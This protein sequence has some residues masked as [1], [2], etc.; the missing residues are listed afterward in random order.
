MKLKDIP[1]FVKFI[2]SCDNCEDCFSTTDSEMLKFVV[3]ESSGE[4]ISGLKI[5]Q[6]LQ[7]EPIDEN[8]NK[9]KVI[10]II[11]R[12]LFNDTDSHKY[13]F[14]SQDCT[15]SQG[16]NKEWLFSLLIKLKLQ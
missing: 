5:G 14:D 3:N 11:I 7:F 16:E 6:V 10:D 8:P 2:F 4:P 15:T 1:F 13:G 9:Y 12:H